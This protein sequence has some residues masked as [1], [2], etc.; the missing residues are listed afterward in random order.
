MAAKHEIVERN[1]SIHSI[2]LLLTL[3][4]QLLVSRPNIFGQDSMG[5][6]IFETLFVILV[7]FCSRC[8]GLFHGFVWRTILRIIRIICAKEVHPG[9]R[10]KF[11]LFSSWMDS[12]SLFSSWIDL[13]GCNGLKKE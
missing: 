4:N 5:H 9:N 7:H 12:S 6:H 11:F 1:E 8:S 10:L 3:P 2:Q 13:F